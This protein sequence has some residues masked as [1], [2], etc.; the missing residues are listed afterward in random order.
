MPFGLPY[1]SGK[2]AEV[3][4]QWGSL[5]AQIRQTQASVSDCDP[6]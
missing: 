6:G 2:M 3:L 5:E 1:D 4:R